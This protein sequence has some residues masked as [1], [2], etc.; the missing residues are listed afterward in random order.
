MH[1]LTHACPPD[2]SGLMPCCGRTPFEVSSMDRLTIEDRLVTCTPTRRAEIKVM[3]ARDRVA[4]LRHAGARRDW[5]AADAL[6][7][8]K[9]ELAFAEEALAR[10][11]PTKNT[12]TLRIE[13]ERWCIVEGWIRIMDGILDPDSLTSD[14][15]LIRQF[16]LQRLVERLNLLVEKVDA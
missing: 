9:A 14:Y 13:G 15:V 6:D 4:S 8:A 12:Y 5:R 1:E 2:G 7:E 3:E 10:L 11:T 16:D